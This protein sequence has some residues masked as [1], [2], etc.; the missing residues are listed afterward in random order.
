[1]IP[2]P[3]DHR[4]KH[5]SGRRAQASRPFLFLGL[6]R[7]FDAQEAAPRL[8]VSSGVQARDLLLPFSVPV[9]FSSP[10]LPAHCVSLRATSSINAE[11]ARS[12]IASSAVY[13]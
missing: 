2:L 8:R 1:V 9:Y 11:G 3:R 6:A 13:S 12:N 10:N 4:F 7:H 5:N